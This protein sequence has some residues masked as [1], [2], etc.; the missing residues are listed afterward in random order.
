MKLFVIFTH[1]EIQNLSPRAL[2]KMF[3]LMQFTNYLANNN[4]K[5]T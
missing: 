4:I 3:I 5:S 1:I 2:T